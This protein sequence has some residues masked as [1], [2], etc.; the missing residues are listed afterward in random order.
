MFYPSNLFILQCVHFCS[1]QEIPREKALASGFSKAK[2]DD[3][4][5][6]ASSPKG[7]SFGKDTDVPS[8]SHQGG[9]TL[10]TPAPLLGVEGSGSS[11]DPLQTPK[12]KVYIF[13]TL[14]FASLS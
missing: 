10:E 5:K 1:L 9:K 14:I 7:K 2:N 12:G 6:R 11:C 13:L 3:P 8:S 4:P